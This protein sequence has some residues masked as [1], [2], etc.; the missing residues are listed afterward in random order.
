[1]IHFMIIFLLQSIPPLYSQAA[2][3]E[4]HA[5]QWVMVLV[6]IGFGDWLDINLRNLLANTRHISDPENKSLKFLTAW[7]GLLQMYVPWLV[8]G[9]C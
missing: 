6:L 4:D 7:L 2:S 5:T 1:M 8:L 3:V 9:T